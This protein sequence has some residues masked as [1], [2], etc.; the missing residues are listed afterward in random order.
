MMWSTMGGKSLRGE[1]T[2]ERR[3]AEIERFTG[4]IDYSKGSALHNIK[5]RRVEKFQQRQLKRAHMLQRMGDPTP[6]KQSGKFDR[7]T[8]TLNVFAKTKRQ[9]ERQTAQ[10]ARESSVK[11]SGRAG[12]R[13][14][15]QWD[16]HDVDPSRHIVRDASSVM[17]T[18]RAPKKSNK[19]AKK[20]SRGKR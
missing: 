4:D 12:K 15:S 8:G 7:F 13:R 14:S 5:D 2:E 1:R 11:Q 20:A 16:V 18:G 6:M 10:R 19:F 3:R 17:R 9:V